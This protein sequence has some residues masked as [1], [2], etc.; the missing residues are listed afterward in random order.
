M[1]NEVIKLFYTVR[2]IWTETGL[3]MATDIQSHFVATL[4]LLLLGLS[5][6]KLYISKAWTTKPTV[7]KY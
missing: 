6:S 3:F 2:N 4:V 1:E 7:R 5:F